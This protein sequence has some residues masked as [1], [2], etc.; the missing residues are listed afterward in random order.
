MPSEYLRRSQDNS[1][2]STWSC[3]S[4]PSTSLR[5]VAMFRYG[6]ISGRKIPSVREVPASGVN[7]QAGSF[8]SSTARVGGKTSYYVQS[9]HGLY[10]ESEVEFE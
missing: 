8:P 7:T 9:P 3:P 6:Q 5:P 10:L 4:S 1:T 2:S